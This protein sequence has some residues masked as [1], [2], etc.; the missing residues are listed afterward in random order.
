MDL[1][2]IFP[3]VIELFVKFWSLEFTV[4]GIELTV[5]AVICWSAL[6]GMVIGFLRR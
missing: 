4:F 2:F 1:G 5:G 6:V 3:P